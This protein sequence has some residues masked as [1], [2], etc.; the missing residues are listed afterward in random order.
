MLFFMVVDEGDHTNKMTLNS[1]GRL[2][3]GRDG[4]SLEVKLI[5]YQSKNL[6]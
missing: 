3:E 5:L 1:K 6:I 2:F 4:F